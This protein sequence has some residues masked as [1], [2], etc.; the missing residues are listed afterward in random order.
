[1]AKIAT[2]CVLLLIGCTCL[3]GLSSARSVQTSRKEGE[4]DVKALS[5]SRPYD[6]RCDLPGCEYDLQLYCLDNGVILMGSCS[7]KNYLC[8][9]GVRNSL[10]LAKTWE[11]CFLATYAIIHHD[12]AHVDELPQPRPETGEVKEKT[13]E[14]KGE[15][16]G[17]KGEEAGEPGLPEGEPMDLAKQQ[18]EQELLTDP[19]VNVKVNGAVQG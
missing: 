13:K 17:V 2:V 19:Q 18:L 7:L 10:N 14:M 5:V 1:M 8:Q 12:Q 6:V 16:A 3:T 4:D 9:N 15:E 11:S